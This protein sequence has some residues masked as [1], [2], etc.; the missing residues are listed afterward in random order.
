MVCANKTTANPPIAAKAA[1]LALSMRR[2]LPPAVMYRKPAQARNSAAAASPTFV[3]ASSSVS[4]SRIIG[5]GLLIESPFGLECGV[6]RSRAPDPTTAVKVGAPEAA[7]NGLDGDGLAF[8]RRVDLQTA[9]DVDADVGNPVA[10]IGVCN[11]WAK[12]ATI[13]IDRGTPDWLRDDAR[14]AAPNT[15]GSLWGRCQSWQAARGRP[16]HCG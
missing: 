11:R 13:G 12:N 4:N 10:R 9:A 14:L 2:G 1:S 7:E 8:G 3:A 6:H 15:Y 16:A 5:C